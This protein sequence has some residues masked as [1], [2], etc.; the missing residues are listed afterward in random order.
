MVIIEFIE[1]PIDENNDDYYQLIHKIKYINTMNELIY[2]WRL[3]NINLYLELK[4]N[5]FNDRFNLYN[6]TKSKL[7][8]HGGRNLIIKYFF[9]SKHNQEETYNNISKSVKRMVRKNDKKNNYDY[10]PENYSSDN[11]AYEFDSE[12]SIN[13]D[14]DYE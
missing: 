11:S 13:F 7:F 1:I 2:I 4:H 9:Y 10:E 3:C 6:Q 14:S 5:N 8:P 12:D